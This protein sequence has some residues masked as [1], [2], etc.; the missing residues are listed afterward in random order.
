MW[1]TGLVTFPP[2]PVG[3]IE[4]ELESKRTGVR[5]SY[6]VK[7]SLSFSYYLIVARDLVFY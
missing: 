1:V 6:F 4:I 5:I 2:L 3:F 7:S